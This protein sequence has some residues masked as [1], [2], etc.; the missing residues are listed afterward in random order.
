MKSQIRSSSRIAARSEL[1]EALHR[2][3]REPGNVLL[4]PG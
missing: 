4:D 1:V 3:A 2:D